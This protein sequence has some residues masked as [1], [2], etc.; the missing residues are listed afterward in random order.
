MRKS[1]KSTKKENYDFCDENC[2]CDDNCC[3]EDCQTDCH[4]DFNESLNKMADE[5]KNCFEKAKQTWKKQPAERKT[6]VKKGIV[7]GLAIVGGL[8]VLS[9]IFGRRHD[10]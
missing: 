6:Q 5:G 8:Y 4:F 9:K 10:D 1:D 7:G 3:G 2:N